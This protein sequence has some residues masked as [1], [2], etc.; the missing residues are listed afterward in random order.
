MNGIRGRAWA[1]PCLVLLISLAS[2]RSTFAQGAG[3]GTL[4]GTVVDK[5]GVVPGAVVAVTETATNAVRTAPTNE[6][7]VFRIPALPPGQYTLKVEVSG[8]KPLS[9]T[10][11]A[12]ITGEIRD[13]GKLTL[14]LGGQ[15]ESVTVTAEVT[16]VQV[17]S[18]SRASAIT[19]DQLTNIQMKGRDIYGLMAIL[20][21][22]QDTNLNRD[23]STW[24][25]MRDI[26]INGAPVTSKN[27]LVDGISVVDEGGTGNAFVNPNIDAVGE[28]QV[29]AN[30]YTAENGRN[31][32]GLVSMVTKS[33]SNSFKGSGW[34]NARRDKWN[35][36]DYLRIKQN[37]AKPLY[38]VNIGGYSIGGPVVLPK[39][40]DS[41][42]SHKKVYFFFSQEYTDDARP[43]NV[44]RWNLPTAKERLGDFSETRVTNGSIQ[45]IIDPLTGKAFPGNI[46][47]ANR[48]NPMGQA[49]LNLMPLP[50]GI[51]NPVA[52]QEWTSNSAFDQ[53]PLHSRTDH[54]FRSDV[55]L[56]DKTRFSGKVLADREDNISNNQFAPGLGIVNNFVP[57]YVVSGAMTRVLTPRMVNEINLGFGHN[58]YGFKGDYDYKQ[59]YRSAIGIDPPRLAPFLA[60]QDPPAITKRQAD[61]YPYFPIISYGGGNRSNLAG[62]SPGAVNG[63]VMPTAN[64]NN[65]WSFQDDLSLTSGRH[66][67]KFGFYTELNS[68]TEPG[69]VNYMGNYNFGSNATNPFDTGNGYANGLLGIF[70]TYTETSVR[71]D[72]DTRHWQTEFY[73]QD[74]WRMTSRFTLDYGLRFTHSGAYFETNNA[75][76]GFFGELYDPKV[77]PRL[78]VPVCSN[79]AAGNQA[80]PAANR[81]AADPLNPTKL[82]SSAYVGNIV[83]GSGDFLTGMKQGGL[84]GKGHYFS[85]PYLVAAPRVG[86]A[87]DVTGDGRTA[88]RASTGIFYNFPRGGYNFIGFPPVS[89][90]R[91]IRNATINDIAN[92][93]TVGVQSADNPISA[94]YATLDGQKKTM[95]RSYN[96]N[97]AFQ[98]DLGFSTVVE[99]AW[100]GNYTYHDARTIQL[101][102]IP[103]Y[104]YANAKNLFNQ[105][106]I[107]QNFLRTAF[108][109]M[110]SITDT[111]YD[112]NS[113]IYNSMQTSV[114]R[115]LSKGLQMGMAYT[116]SKGEGM[117]GYDE[118]T[119]QIGGQQALHDRYW[120]PTSVD[121]RH[122][123]SVNYSYQIPTVNRLPAAARWVLQDWQVSGVTKFQSGNP[124]TPTCTSNNAGINNSDP[125]LSGLG[126]NRC[127]LTGEPL[128]SGFTVDPD[129]SVAI[130]FNP[131]AFRMPQPNGSIG[132]FGNT[133]IGILRNPSWSN[134]DVT[135]A[136]RFPVKAINRGAQVR[137]QLQLYNIFN[138]V[139]FTTMDVT[140]RYSGTN[141]SVNQQ[142]TTGRYTVTTPP[143]QFGITARLDF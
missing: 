9:M 25:S 44:Q 107:N 135:F 139:Q 24:T 20:P 2:V 13:L 22:V 15:A 83:P 40:L 54:V 23:F 71:V 136:R 62:Y 114:Q 78:Y 117:Q 1:L 82:V 91:V 18:S 131:N 65:R 21:G 102:P 132:N 111:V 34:Y 126:G 123:L 77:A 68:K 115:R 106:A 133:P 89:F 85:F 127:E 101:N 96:G 31:N 46:I 51:T 58:N 119:D 122:N 35:A 4:T 16:P 29:I 69:S 5:D 50:N 90:D 97:V 37:L 60:Y 128:Y 76:A 95:P 103:L 11:I 17:A 73:V 33:G 86:F 100:V 61:Q 138:Q 7:G 108:P 57:G 74:S 88:L 94:G 14:Q 59:Y 49:I 48:I 116:L 75:N 87:W 63:R 28:M 141:N 67:Y 81:F 55:V 36:N 38:R 47:P 129:P 125:T 27:V 109:G 140:F 70:Q 30:G 72:K 3:A 41:R 26:T 8:F 142:S 6:A 43:T 64:R 32:G 121:R 105:A 52:G 99:V 19:S 92:A 84:D 118:F 66:S 124:L 137:L 112:Q 10:G 42:T 113:L 39:L 110:G 98:R 93:A 53:T 45:P 104:A 12:L 134:W 130:H 80:C 56:S 143:R 79:G 120:G